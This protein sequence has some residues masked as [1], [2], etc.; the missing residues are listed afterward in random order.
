MAEKDES[1][2]KIALESKMIIEQFQ[3]LLGVYTSTEALA[4]IAVL[5]REE[6]EIEIELN[7]Y[8]E[9]V[10]WIYSIVSVN[11]TD[12]G[13]AHAG[14]QEGIEELRDKCPAVTNGVHLWCVNGFDETRLC[15]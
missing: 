7:K 4:K 1:I 11:C 3:K 12:V 5:M 8:K 14:I 2:Y 13:E 6:S 9:L 10:D 15:K